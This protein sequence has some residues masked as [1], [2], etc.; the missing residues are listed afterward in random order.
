MSQTNRLS[1][2]IARAVARL[3]PREFLL[4]LD[5]FRI[6]TNNVDSDKA[7][8]VT[9][10][11]DGNLAGLDATGNLTDSGKA[12][13]SGDIVGTTDTQTLTNKTIDGDNNSLSNLDH[14]AEVDNPSSGVHGVAGSVVGTT[15]TQTLSNKTLTTPTIGD[16][17]N[18]QH[19]H[20]AAGGGGVL[21]HGLAL[22]GLA[23]DDHTQYHNDSRG[24]AR[25]IGWTADGL[26]PHLVA[27]AT[28]DYAEHGGAISTIG[29][30]V[31]LPDNAIVIRSWYEVITT[32]TS[33]TDAATV[34]I[35]IPIDDP[36]GIVAAIA[37]SDVSNPWDAGLHEGIQDGT[38]ANAANK[39]TL[40]R[41]LSITIA[42]EAV[43]AGKFVLFCEYIVSD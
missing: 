4:W 10:A 35:D 27:R 20:Q 28:Y 40:A 39:T 13:P 1:T 33:A 25:Y 11:T 18:A 22:S 37:I 9:G 5:T 6:N 26:H 29:L 8:K 41:E 34:A 31:T 17:S 30:G 21:D 3:L 36:A 23:D 2:H 38:V 32:L 7:D 24:D 19:N 16:F 14:G 43:T 15:D 42:V 12:P